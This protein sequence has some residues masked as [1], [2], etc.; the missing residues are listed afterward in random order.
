M[1]KRAK[2]DTY[3]RQRN[4][5]EFRKGFNKSIEKSEIRKKITKKKG[6]NWKENRKSDRS[7]KRIKKR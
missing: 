5:K 6:F 1:G 7:I 3:E 2:P 4:W